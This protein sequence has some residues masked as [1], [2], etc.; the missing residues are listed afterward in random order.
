MKPPRAAFGF[1]IAE[2]DHAMSAVKELKAV[3]RDRV[4]KGAARAVRRQG[5]VPAVIY[6]GGAPAEAI[7]LDFNQMKLAIYAGH[8]LTTIFEIDVEGRKT[9]ALP[10]DYQ[11]DPVKD[12]PTHID[13]MRLAAGQ[14]IRV[15][16][17]VHVVGQ[18]TSPGIKRGGTVQV[19]QHSLE[20]MVPTEAIPDAVEVSVAELDIGGTIHLSDVILP[21]GARAIGSENVTIATVIVPTA[22]AEEP[23][24]AAAAPAAETPAAGG[25]AAAG[26]AAKAPAA[27]AA[28]APAGGAKAPAASAKAPAAGA[29]APAKPGGKG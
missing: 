25:K 11:L 3:A 2:K 1:L 24:V 27:G 9:R 10:R 16:V 29:K 20:L 13:F 5:Q 14:K 4:G 12:F 26:G 28:K 7:A 23:A 22:G 15:T 18:E 21:Q 19:V 8:F 6:G 17:P